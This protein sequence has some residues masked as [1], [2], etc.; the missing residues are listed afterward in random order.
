[1]ETKQDRSAVRLPL[2][3]VR[4]ALLLNRLAYRMVG[5][6][7]AQVVTFNLEGAVESGAEILQCDCRRQ[8]DDLCGCEEG[9]QFFKHRVGNFRRRPGH[10]FGIAQHRPLA[11]IKMLAGFEYRNI[12]QLFVANTG[13]SAHGRVDIHSEGTTNHLRSAHRRHDLETWFDC[14]GAVNCPP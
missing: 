10:A 1:M 6:Q 14:I 4:H 3:M 12:R 5:G 8:F 2:I 9:L 11:V 13:L 7:H